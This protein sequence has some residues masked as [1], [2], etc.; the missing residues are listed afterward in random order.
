MELKK[1]KNYKKIE[2]HMHLNSK[3]KMELKITKNGTSYALKL[4]KNGTSYSL[5]FQKN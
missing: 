1:S 5:K 3:K 2:P 4:K